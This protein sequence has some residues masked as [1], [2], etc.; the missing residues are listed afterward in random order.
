MLK[1]ALSMLIGALAAAAVSVA[2]AGIGIAP[3]PMDGWMLI[4]GKW[5]FGVTQG[6]NFTYASGIVAHAG[7]TQAAC[8][9]LPTSI[10]L[11]EVDTVAT[12]GDSVCIP[13]GKQGADFSI[14]NAGAQTLSVYAQSSN[15]ELGGIDTINGT[16][17]S[18]AYSIPANNSAECFA[19]K[20]GAW[21][22]AHGN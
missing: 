14:R 1:T 18:T 5:L 15:N 19:A 8:F 17:G 16:A 12:T 3:A 13:H 11:Y 22:C 9:N 2:M 7:G 20:T 10:A 21:S 4:E 6:I